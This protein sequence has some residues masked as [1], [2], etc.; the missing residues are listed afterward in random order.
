ML[1]LVPVVKTRRRRRLA[2]AVA[3]LC[4]LPGSVEGAVSLLFSFPFQDIK[5]PRKELS[6]TEGDFK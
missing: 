5:T 1:M 3:M 6:N 4:F 2:I